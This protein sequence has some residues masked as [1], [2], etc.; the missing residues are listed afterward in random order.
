MSGEKRLR[1]EVL[2]ST[3]RQEVEKREMECQTDTHFGTASKDPKYM[4]NLWDQR[5]EAIKI[6][7]LSKK[8]THSTQTENSDFRREK[9]TQHYAPKGN[10]TQTGIS[11]S[12]N[13]ATQKQV[14]TGLRGDTQAR[15]KV[16]NI[17]MDYHNK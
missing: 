13:V 6:V 1:E 15:M 10:D 14:V 16:V 2:K 17:T 8:K 11:R 4:P 12:T 9:T 5:R 7:D 3:G